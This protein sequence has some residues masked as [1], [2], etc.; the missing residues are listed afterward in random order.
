MATRRRMV[1]EL[2]A[3][4]AKALDAFRTLTAEQRR[5]LAESEKGTHAASRQGKA[6]RFLTAE[7][8][9]LV[10]AGIGMIGVNEAID[11]GIELLREYEEHLKSISERQ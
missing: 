9:S 11:D 8:E 5:S 10:A 3:E 2:D 7:W 1:Y 4:E 6:V